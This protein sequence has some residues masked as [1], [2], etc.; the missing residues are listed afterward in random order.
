MPAQRHAA[1]LTRMSSAAST[2]QAGHQVR[3]KLGGWCSPSCS[4]KLVDHVV[5]LACLPH[6]C[7]PN[8]GLLRM[9]LQSA[10]SL[11]AMQCSAVP[12]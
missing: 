5:V 2:H 7:L 11:H 1:V 12:S 4:S 10:G 6:A 8:K 3:A 9:T